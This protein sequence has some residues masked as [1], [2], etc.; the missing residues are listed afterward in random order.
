MVAHFKT[1]HAVFLTHGVG[2]QLCQALQ[3]RQVFGPD[4][5]FA[6]AVKTTCRGMERHAPPVTL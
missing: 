5:A 2:G 1:E 6:A 3:P 4:R